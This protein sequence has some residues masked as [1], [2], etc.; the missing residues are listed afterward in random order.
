MQFKRD[1]LLAALEKVGVPAGPINTV[2]DV[3]E[4]PQVR[5]REMRVDLP[6]PSVAGG[7]V[8]T[9]RSPLMLD[10]VAMVAGSAP[11]R[12][13]EHTDEVLADPAWIGQNR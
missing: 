11:P 9:V 1:D 4:D 3:F 7:S 10:G 6:A 8:P 5:A 12:L 13:G 2:A